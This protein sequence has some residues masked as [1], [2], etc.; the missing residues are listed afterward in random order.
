MPVKLPVSGPFLK[1]DNWTGGHKNFFQTCVPFQKADK[2]THRYYSV[3]ACETVC[4]WS[5]FKSGQLDRRTQDF[6]S[7]PCPISKS[8]QVD[9]QILLSEFLSNCL[10]SCPLL[11]WTTDRQ[12]D[13]HSLS[14]ICESTCLLFEIGQGFEKNSYVLLS[15]CPLLKMDHCQ[16]S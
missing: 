12:F 14:S 3:N 7:N 5:I 1:V 9:S 4:Q 6:F 8:R 16:S 15:S 13:R 2:W 10:S 11:K